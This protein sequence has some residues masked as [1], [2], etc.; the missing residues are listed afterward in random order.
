MIVR[1]NGTVPDELGRT[2]I[3]LEPEYIIFEEDK[4][5]VILRKSRSA[6]FGVLPAVKKEVLESAE[7]GRILSRFADSP[8]HVVAVADGTPVSYNVSPTTDILPIHVKLYIEAAVPESVGPSAVAFKKAVEEARRLNKRLGEIGVERSRLLDRLNVAR[9]L[10]PQLSRLAEEETELKRRFKQAL[11]ERRAAWAELSKKMDELGLSGLLKKAPDGIFKVYIPLLKQEIT[12]GVRG[13]A[14][15]AAGF[16]HRRALRLLGYREPSQHYKVYA[17]SRLVKDLNAARQNGRSESAIWFRPVLRFVAG[18]RF[19][20]H[21]SL[22]GRTK[23][24]TILEEQTMPDPDTLVRLIRENILQAFGGDLEV[25][26]VDVERLLGGIKPIGE[27][28]LPLPVGLKISITF[29]P[30]EVKIT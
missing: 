14:A 18:D 1:L 6:S 24:V 28:T 16:I 7:V 8:D 9:E 29:K 23:G 11:T 3:L 13:S 10:A 12:A 15:S 25:R 30:K 22:N 2:V 17:V 26:D 20:A 19:T 5:P 21:L 4:L 27:T